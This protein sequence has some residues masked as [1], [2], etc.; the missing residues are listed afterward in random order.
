MKIRT[1]KIKKSIKLVFEDPLAYNKPDDFIEGEERYN[2]LGMVGNVV[3][4]V[5][6]T[7]RLKAGQ[8]V[9]RII[10]ARKATN[11]ERSLYEKGG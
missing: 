9:I 11:Y 5:V 4:F 3:L 6:H 7:Y 10:S 1:L 8:E 2:T